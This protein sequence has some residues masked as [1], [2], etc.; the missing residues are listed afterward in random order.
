MPQV[1]V[2]LTEDTVPNLW[3]QVRGGRPRRDGLPAAGAERASAPARGV[4]H[5]TI[6]QE[7]LVLVCAA[8]IRSR[9]GASRRSHAA[10][11]YDW[12]LPPEGSYTRL[13][14]EQLFMRAGL[15][16]PRARHHV[17]ELPLQPAARRRMQPAR[18]DAAL[19]RR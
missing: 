3:L 6:G 12:V 10:A 4:A 8:T 7:S 17:D 1:H 2:H 15:E 13:T 19:G 14:I 9:A 16:Q 18:G 11:S 5:R